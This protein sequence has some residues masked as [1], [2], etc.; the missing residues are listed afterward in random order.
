MSFSAQLGSLLSQEVMRLRRILSSASYGGTF[1]Q[2]KASSGVASR[3]FICAFSVPSPGASRHLLPM[4]NAFNVAAADHISYRF[5]TFY[6]SLSASPFHFAIKNTAE[7]TFLFSFL[8]Y[9]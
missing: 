3:H 1:F 8:S 5:T 7:A 9:F 2:K 6:I 4:K